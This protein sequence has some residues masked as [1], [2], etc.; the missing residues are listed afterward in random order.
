MQ[1]MQR[2]ND[3]SLQN[4]GFNDC[5]ESRVTNIRNPILPLDWFRHGRLWFMLS[6]M[7]VETGHALS[8]PQFFNF[9]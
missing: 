7:A 4:V 2:L 1:N 5:R 8:L 3:Y 9:F 6:T